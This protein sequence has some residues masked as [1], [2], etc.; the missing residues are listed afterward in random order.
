MEHE[1]ERRHGSATPAPASPLH[2]SSSS[3]KRAVL[4]VPATA[5]PRTLGKSG[6]ERL[7]PW[8]VAVIAAST[9]YFA[10]AVLVPI[11]LAILLSFLLSPIVAAFRRA[12]LP[13]AF[14]VLLAM[15]MALSGIA[16]TTAIIA[17][18]AASLSKDA[19]L[20][21][22]RITEKAARLHQ[23]VQQ[24]FGLLLHE[25]QDGGGG[26]R[27]ALRA[28]QESA[29]ALSSRPTTNAIP[30]E[31]RTP[32]LTPIEE[33]RAFVVPALAPLETALIVLIV[34]VF[35]LFQKEDLRDRLIRLMGAADLHRTTL[36]LDDGAKR[37]SRYFFSQFIVN[38]G[39]GAVIWAGLF[40]IG[41]P[42][43][44]LWGILAGLL[45][46]IPY[47]GTVV[48]LLGPLALAAAVDPGWAMVAWVL[49]LFVF[50]EPIVGY[51]IEPLLYG[52]S[53][54]ISPLSVVVAAL[55]WTWIWGP[56][57]L[58]LSMPLTLMLVVLG[59]HVPTFEVFDILLGDRPALSPAET[60]YQRILAGHADE[61][62]EQGEDLLETLT[63]AAYYDEVV[64]PGLRLAVA[65]VDRGAV[66]RAALQP[67]CR[68]VMDILDAFSDHQDVEGDGT[69][70]SGTRIAPAD[71]DDAPNA[72]V[73]GGS[74]ICFPGRGPLD[75]AVSAMMA[76]LL[77]R[78][79]RKVS[80]EV[81]ESARSEMDARVERAQSTVI[82]FLGLF[83]E[84]AFRRMKPLVAQMGR[85]K[86]LVGV[87]RSGEVSQVEDGAPELIPTLAAYLEAVE[88]R[89][90]GVAPITAR[91]V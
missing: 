70:L 79:G 11:T 80:E 19:P 54:G 42:S 2:P 3:V 4:A 56:I 17:T 60:F 63:L 44:G 38:C 64:L 62:I 72:P 69:P 7:V 74:V 12:R 18:Q 10:Q 43:P 26:H 20:Y 48:A 84:R 41:V 22:Q 50:I 35:I 88:N 82:C 61:A 1:N 85:D 68:T 58:V 5:V 8:L 52:H 25:S 37:L 51:V 24:R 9:L 71:V 40:V 90:S 81:R 75:G 65:D 31:V 32:A 91:A 53:T 76:Q 39:F 49:L 16:A 87:R 21:A 14:A 46:F 86:V 73:A 36:A 83:D 47:V 77:R 67:L 15:V 13:R 66:E 33:V 29:R 45:R 59:R 89:S 55:F 6:I 78:Q 28:R 34:T 57:G 30:V 23:G 27:K